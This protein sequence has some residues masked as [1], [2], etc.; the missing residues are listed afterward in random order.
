MKKGV[1]YIGV[2]TGTMILND[3][4]QL[5]LA[6]RRGYLSPTNATRSGGLI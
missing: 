2:A 4:G 5:F 1:D 3:Q 6:K